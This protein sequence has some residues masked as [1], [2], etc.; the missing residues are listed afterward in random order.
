MS[1]AG[2]PLRVGLIGCG[3]IAGVHVRHLRPLSAVRIVGVCDRDE[4]RARALGE[5]VGV[6]EVFR[7]A[8]DLLGLGLDVVHVLTPPT[9]HADPAIA[10][11][12]RGLHVLVEKPMATT[13]EAARRMQAA[14]AS[15][16]RILCV[17]HNRLFDPVILQARGLVASGAI[18]TLLSA[19]AYQGVNVQEGGPAAAPLAMW[20]NL[21][22]HP[23]YLLR[24]F[25]GE[26]GDWQAYGGPLGELRAVFKGERGL[27]YLCFSPGASPY[28]NALTLHGTRATLH[29][30]LNTMT[31]LTR[32]T[33][34]LPSMLSKAAL[35]VEQAV[36]LLGATAR[37]SYRVATRRMG[38]YPGI[39]E[40][41]RRFYDAVRAGGEP[42][43]AAADGLAVVELLEEVWA[44]THRPGSL[45]S[46]RRVVASRPRSSSGKTVLVTGASG[47]LGRHVVAAL[48]ERG[49]RVRAM[50]RFPGAADDWDDVEE[51]AATL[52]DDASITSALAGVSAVVHCAARVAR[53]GSRAD[54]FQDNVRGTTHLLEAAR[55]AG[56]ERFVHV[57]SIAVYGVP[58]RPG[59]VAEDAG[60]DPHPERRGAYTWSKL[61]ADRAVLEWGRRAG[62]ATVTL[63]PGIL[64]GPDGPRFTAR[65]S[66][67]R[68][69]DRVLIVGRPGARLPL[70][71]VADAARAAASAVTAAGA[72][73]AYN[74]VDDALTQDEWLRQRPL[75]GAPLR[76]IYIPPLLAAVPALGLELVARLAGREAPGLSRY[77]IRRATESLCYDTTRARRDLGWVPETGLGARGARAPREADVAAAGGSV[78]M[79]ERRA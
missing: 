64:V 59:P 32:R 79:A 33:R 10:A 23:L 65:L 66:L 74:L 9:A 62:L 26:I 72:S 15:S 47:F 3:R 6:S 5:S 19:E 14:A 57:S 45:P 28:L 18:G 70:C 34:R 63:R 77:K 69:R 71:H 68:V 24:A 29:V 78:A 8:G 37:T 39:G 1:S 13:A 38:T 56:V 48:R 22:P 35:N 76:P 4:E 12:E 50:V 67:G 20:L 58:S 41:I 25:V 46:V 73:G 75:G 36:Q 27:G 54:F 60:Y 40:V 44:R 30:D 31:L 42:P 43:V 49:H 61:E 52:G 55:A 51:V 53:G 2:S 17:D 11:L 7:D 16:G 21:A